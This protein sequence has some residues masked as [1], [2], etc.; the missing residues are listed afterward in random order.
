MQNRLP[1]PRST[2]KR[3]PASRFAADHLNM[4][5]VNTNHL[6]TNQREANHSTARTLPPTPIL[7][8]R[9]PAKSRSHPDPWGSPQRLR[10]VA[11]LGGDGAGAVAVAAVAAVANR[12]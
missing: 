1:L 6:N 3:P 5:R 2:K 4:N 11:R 8:L 7:N 10:E 12:R 9:V